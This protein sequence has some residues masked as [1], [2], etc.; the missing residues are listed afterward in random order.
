MTPQIASLVLYLFST[1]FTENFVLIFVLCVLLLAADF[2]TVKVRAL[3]PRARG[4]RPLLP[5]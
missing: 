1:L 5:R 4:P 3:A 2:W